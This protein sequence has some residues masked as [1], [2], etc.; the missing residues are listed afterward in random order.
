MPQNLQ[1]KELS[2]K[3]LQA[4]LIAK[5][6]QQQ[7]DKI[8]ERE[9]ADFLTSLIQKAETK[10]DALKLAALGTHLKR[11]GF[12]FDMR[13]EKSDRTIRYATR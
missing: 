13:L 3:E 8:L 10:G 6:K 9:N 5:L 11:T 1:E 12:H 4:T 7:E 2:L